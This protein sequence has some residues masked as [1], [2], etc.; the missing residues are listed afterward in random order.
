MR[1]A[2]T[3]VVWYFLALFSVLGLFLLGQMPQLWHAKFYLDGQSLLDATPAME[4]FAGSYRGSA[5]LF[6]PLFQL[7]AH[8]GLDLGQ[9]ASRFDHAWLLAN[10]LWALPYLLMV[11]CVVWRLGARGGIGQ[12][13]V[14]FCALVLYAP[15][16]GSIN[17][18]IVPALMMFAVTLMLAA[19]RLGAAWGVFLVLVLAYGLVVRV[20]FL[21]FGAVFVLA[22]FLVDSRMKLMAA[23]LAGSAA[24]IIAFPHI[25]RALIDIGRAEYLE[26]V[27]S[28]RIHYW[29]DDYAPTGFAINRIGAIIRV[30]LPLELL[31]KSP[32]YAPFVL[33]RCHVT[34]LT[35]RALGGA[36]G[37]RM[38]ACI[39]LSFTVTQAVFEP[40]FGSAFRHFMMAMPL[41]IYLQSALA[42]GG[43][44]AR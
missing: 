42:R 19:G 39:L 17:K 9:Y 11:W 38:A 10:L 33:F 12:L 28:T 5:W 7:A 16:Y 15:F 32:A 25:P 2:D 30:A 37:V 31:L 1:A 26:D 13:F 6:S 27:A 18:D 23:L 24:V 20:Y 29:L 14:L 22:F 34:L 21:L 41:V 4:L 3:A 40:D 36:G 44:E 43:G 35:L 8:A